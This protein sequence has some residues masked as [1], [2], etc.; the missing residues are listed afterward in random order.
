MF[1]VQNI[2]I[3]IWISGGRDVHGPPYIFCL[4]L[5]KRKKYKSMTYTKSNS[6]S[7][8]F[9]RTNKKNNKSGP[10]N[11]KERGA[12]RRCNWANMSR[13]VPCDTP[14]LCG[15]SPC[16]WGRRGLGE[17]NILFFFFIHFP[18]LTF[19]Y[20]KSILLQELIYTP[21]RVNL[22]SYKSFHHRTVK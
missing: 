1:Y 18:T 8:F 7:F 12:K 14:T 15:Q 11:F 17:R 9:S 2:S 3:Y 19:S 22:Y 10:Q 13:V 21:T 4:L 6:T 5:K 16:L 20:F